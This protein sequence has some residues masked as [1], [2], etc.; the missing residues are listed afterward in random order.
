MVSK[1][2]TTRGQG[3]QIVGGVEDPGPELAEPPRQGELLA[4]AAQR[5]LDRDPL[6]PFLF[7][8]REGEAGVFAPPGLRGG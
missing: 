5:Q 2:V 6:E 4:Q 7:E 1:T 3:G 8:L